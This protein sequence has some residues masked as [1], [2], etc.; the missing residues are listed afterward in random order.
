ME[1]ED[2][3]VEF[4]EEDF[5]KKKELLEFEIWEEI[6]DIREERKI[7]SELLNKY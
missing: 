5:I 2:K 1:N 7:L 6:K 4:I 3:D